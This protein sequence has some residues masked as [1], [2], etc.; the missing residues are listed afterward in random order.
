ME[1]VHDDWNFIPGLSPVAFHAHVVWSGLN[2]IVTGA[3]VDY[4]YRAWKDG[5][6][7]DAVIPLSIYSREGKIPDYFFFKPYD[8][9][10]ERW[11]LGGAGFLFIV[12]SVLAAR[13]LRRGLS[14]GGPAA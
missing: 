3:P 7:V 5:R 2:E 14:A 13:G 12:L 11:S 6:F 4:V 1:F 9:R 8:T 10:L